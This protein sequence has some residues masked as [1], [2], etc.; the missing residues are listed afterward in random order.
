MIRYHLQNDGSY[1]VSTRRR[2]RGHIFKDV[3]YLEHTVT[4]RN[5]AAYTV[6]RVEGW[7]PV[8]LNGVQ[9][10]VFYTKRAAAESLVSEGR[11]LTKSV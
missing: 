8:G 9:G 3:E 10:R 2:P 7:R 4:G 5:Y 1:L 11:F 6:E